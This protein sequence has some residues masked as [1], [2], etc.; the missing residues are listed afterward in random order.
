MSGQEA[1]MTTPQCHNCSHSAEI[2]L[3][4][5]QTEQFI[6][7]LR[8]I[9]NDIAFVRREV[10]AIKTLET[11]HNHHKEDLKRAFDRLEKLE[12]AHAAL[13]TLVTTFT[14]RVEGMA[15]MAWIMWTVIGSGVGYIV[16]K[17]LTLSFG[18]HP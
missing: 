17:L 11:E 9:K 4:K 5:Q 7:L 8:E 3:L 15:R 10:T 18:A 2:A 12:T 14:S 16:V 13:Q 1:S 6:E